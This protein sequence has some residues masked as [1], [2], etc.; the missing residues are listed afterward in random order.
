MKTC[1][2][3][4]VVYLVRE[5]LITVSVSLSPSGK[6]SLSAPVSLFCDPSPPQTPTLVTAHEQEVGS[7]SNQFCFGSAKGWILVTKT[8][9]MEDDDDDDN[10]DNDCRNYHLFHT[11]S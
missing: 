5:K 8:S 7:V 4:I 11:E 1:L 10:D 2:L 6:A 3:K 9:M